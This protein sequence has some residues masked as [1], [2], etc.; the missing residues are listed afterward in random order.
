MSDCRCYLFIVWVGNWFFPQASSC[1]RPTCVCLS[2]RLC[3]LNT[4]WD[5]VCGFDRLLMARLN[6]PLLDPFLTCRRRKCGAQVG[7]SVITCMEPTQPP[8]LNPRHLQLKVFKWKVM[9]KSFSLSSVLLLH[10]FLKLKL[11][12]KLLNSFNDP[13]FND[14]GKAA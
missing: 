2:V 9:C 8:Q 12:G 1:A 3:F 13:L 4:L 14:V 11:Q 6:F 7:S 10:M 5:V